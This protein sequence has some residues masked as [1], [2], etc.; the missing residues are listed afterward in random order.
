M[1]NVDL[2]KLVGNTIIFTAL[3]VTVAY[4][5]IN[6]NRKLKKEV[7]GL[8]EKNEKLKKDSESLEDLLNEFGV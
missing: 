8:K 4:V 3:G 5:L 7:K 1:M 2:G 6:D